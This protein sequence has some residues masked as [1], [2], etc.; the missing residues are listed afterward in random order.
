MPDFFGV[1]DNMKVWEYLDFFAASLQGAGARAARRMITDL[2]T[3]VD[4]SAKRD[5]YVEEL[6]RGMKQRLAWPARWCTTRRCSFWT[7]RRR[8]WTPAPAS[9]CANC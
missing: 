9:S 6:S 2:L 5:N 7:S 1:Y 3:L 4:L 8:G